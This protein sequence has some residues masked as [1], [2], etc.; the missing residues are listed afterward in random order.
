[1]YLADR[2]LQSNKT[3][4]S[5]SNLTFRQMTLEIFLDQNQ[6]NLRLNNNL[7]NNPLILLAIFLVEAILVQIQLKLL[8]EGLIFLA[9][10]HRFK[11]PYSMF[12]LKKVITKLTLIAICESNLLLRDKT[13][14]ST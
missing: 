7:N 4:H 12:K 13:I 2:L 5:F 1:M 14:T 3:N 9:N 10:Q 6:F 8:M 11:H